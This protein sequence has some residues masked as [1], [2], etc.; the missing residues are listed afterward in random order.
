MKVSVYKPDQHTDD[1]GNFCLWYGDSGVGKTATPLQTME[2]P[3]NWII[4][5]RGQVDADP[6]E[7]DEEKDSQ[8]S[9]FPVQ[10]F[11]HW[12]LSNCS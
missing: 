3:I 7:K 12:A 4:A 11:D 2:D 10:D 6:D 5:E 8:V 1:R 9:G